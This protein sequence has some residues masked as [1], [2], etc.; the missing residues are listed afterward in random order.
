MKEVFLIYNSKP[1]KYI[2][3]TICAIVLLNV[4]QR[5]ILSLSDCGNVKENASKAVEFGG[6]AYDTYQNIRGNQSNK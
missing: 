2:V 3:F 1:T 4:L 6:Q 5:F